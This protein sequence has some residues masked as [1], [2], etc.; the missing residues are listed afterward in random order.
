MKKIPLCLLVGCLQVVRGLCSDLCQ[1]GVA[2]ISKVIYM[3]AR[4]SSKH[5]KDSQGLIYL[6][7]YIRCLY[8][9]FPGALTTCG[10]TSTLI[11]DW[12]KVGSNIH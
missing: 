1:A 6:D 5:T 10:S 8:Q 9:L 2:L 11:S 7:V 12:S 4:V 3:E